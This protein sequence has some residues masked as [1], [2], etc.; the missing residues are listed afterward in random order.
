[1]YR[2]SLTLLFFAALLFVPGHFVGAAGSKRY[3]SLTLGL[4]VE[5]KVPNMPANIGDDLNYNRNVVRI[6]VARELKLVRL[7]PVS[8]GKPFGNWKPREYKRK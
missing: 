2:L 8:P 3:V 5:E 7:E 4:T 1:M 6:A